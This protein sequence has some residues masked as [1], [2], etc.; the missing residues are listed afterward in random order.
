MSY[1][2]VLIADFL[3]KNIVKYIYNKSLK[4]CISSSKLRFDFYLPDFNICIEFDGMQHFK[5]IDLFGGEEEFEKLK[6]R[7]DIK[8][9]WC[10]VNGVEMIRFNYLQK[11]EDIHEQLE[12]IIYKIKKDSKDE[13]TD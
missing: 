6:I 11:K 12:N 13:S 2:E 1:G 5:P 10:S 8:N 3:D 4:D 9:K 7:D